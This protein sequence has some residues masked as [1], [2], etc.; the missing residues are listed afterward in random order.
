MKKGIE[1][2]TSSEKV[3]KRTGTAIQLQES[4]KVNFVVMG[5]AIF[6]RFGED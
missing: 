3:N 4:F 2:E 1:W 5:K 6:F